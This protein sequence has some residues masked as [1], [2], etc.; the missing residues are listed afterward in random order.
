MDVERFI[1]VLRL[2][3]G[4][5]YVGETKNVYNRVQKHMT[6]PDTSWVKLNPV[7]SLIECFI[8]TKAND[9]DETTKRYMELYG[10]DNVRGGKWC[11]VDLPEEPSNAVACTKCGRYDH[12]H[13]TCTA[14]THV[15]NACYICG[16]T[17]HYANK[18]RRRKK[19]YRELYSSAK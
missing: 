7:E 16:S 2:T 9:E 19:Y 13:E 17:K 5:Y 10:V 15:N 12:I 11:L 4:K 8:S 14:T 6:N 1:Y 3:G 18:C